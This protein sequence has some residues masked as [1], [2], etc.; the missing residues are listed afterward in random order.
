MYRLAQ[1]R[2]TDR[3]Q[4]VASCTPA[5]DA[6]ADDDGDDDDNEAD[7]TLCNSCT[8]R[9]NYRMRNYSHGL[10]IIA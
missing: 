6:D 9:G 3:T 1:K 8:D 7:A 10:M 2:T 5:W 4:S